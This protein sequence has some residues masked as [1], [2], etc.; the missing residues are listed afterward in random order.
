MKSILLLA[1]YN[2]YKSEKKMIDVD[3]FYYS[4][5]QL[6]GY[7]A[8]VDGLHD[9]ID[10]TSKI[11]SH[12]LSKEEMIS[13]IEEAKKLSK[14]NFTNKLKKVLKELEDKGFSISTDHVGN[15]LL[16]NSEVINGEIIDIDPLEQA[17]M[18]KK[19]LIKKIYGQNLAIDA[20]VDS[21][22]NKVV[23]STNSPKHTFLFLG[24]PAT[25]KTYLAKIIQELLN[26]YE[27]LELNMQ[28]Y[29]N[30]Q[31][32]QKIFGV[33]AGWSTAGTGL[34]TSFVK[35][36]PKTVVLLDEFEKAHT[37]VQRRF[38]NIFSEGYLHDANGWV[39]IEEEEVVYDQSNEEHKKGKRVTKV[40]FTQTIFVITS[41]LCS[42]LYNNQDFVQS[43]SGEYD[44]AE[45]TILEALK[46]ERKKEANEDV[47]AIVPE[48]ISRLSQGK[49]VLFDKLNFESL[50]QISNDVFLSKLGE[51][52]RRYSHIEFDFNEQYNSFLECSL[53][54][55]APFMDIRRIKSKLYENFSDQITDCLVEK[56]KLWKDIDT[57][58]IKVSKKAESFLD[59]FV[60]PKIQEKTILKYL[61]RKSLT[62]SIEYS[63]T[64]KGKKVSIN[65]INFSFEKIKKVEDTVG[66]GSILFNIPSITFDDIAGH[67]NVKS[68]LKEIADLLKN[69]EKLKKFGAKI[70]KGM[71]LY[72]VPGTGKT[73]LAKAFSNYAD[74]PFIQ[75]TANEL[76]DPGQNNLD[77]MRS[78]FSRAKDYAPSIVF[79][80][81]I[82]TFG[83]RDGEGSTVF[84]NE[85]L[86]Q[87]NGFSDI[88][89]EA[90]FIIAATNYKEKLDPAIIRP[91]RIELHIEIPTLDAKGREY[92]IRKMLQKPC[93]KDISI[94]KLVMYT[95]GMTGAQLEKVSNESSLYALREG[96]DEISEE[97]FIEQINVEKYGKRVTDK[98]IEAMLGETA[99]HEAGHAVISK[100]LSPENKIEQITVTARED[101]LGFVSYDKE[102]SNSNPSKKDL[103]NKICVAYAGRIAQ[104][105]KYG[106]DG[107]DMGAS[108][109]L[110]YATKLAYV[111]IVK[112]G[113]D[114]E[115]GHINLDGIP[116][117]NAL[118]GRRPEVE[119]IYKHK[120]EER[121]QTLL[122]E[123]YIKTENLVA[124]S[125]N[126]ID[127]L[128]KE[129]LKKEVVH[130][131]EINDIMKTESK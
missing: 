15:T 95:A 74:L 126:K 68:R 32:G 28:D 123:L 3:D 63:I 86:T 38:L 121:M 30:H 9:A 46:T 102:N 39:K 8:R 111:M 96:L 89:E 66:T 11:S 105:K 50:L 116:T 52:K 73:M 76:I 27:F 7:I 19:E 45:S 29:S 71:L 41:N 5:Y 65:I 10:F 53:L 92:F 114:Q 83:S 117:I 61:F 75:T 113:M 2:V 91:G 107:L 59:N 94:S 100:L 69:P 87:I 21:I 14:I 35:A 104:M 60:R 12:P 43:I 128:A 1:K 99:Y 51:L 82:D 115:L 42:E 131:S 62:C 97:V 112:V 36:N 118:F 47:L 90:L 119:A 80:D 120:I 40:D 54:R 67:E 56:E 72:G 127:L 108:S 84:I 129:L 20:I 98:S 109:D 124:T 85:L 48:M 79:I 110:A 106:E 22:K 4:T 88:P 103:E 44:K 6:E 49:I 37:N 55:F 101:T 70:P 25:G 93:S 17:I 23:D 64:L 125:W 33:E 77:T 16:S 18:L 34:M 24:P 122:K 13:H 26:G 58:S 78:I 31:D 81:E 130:E 57:I